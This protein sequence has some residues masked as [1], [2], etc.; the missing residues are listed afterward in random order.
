MKYN[1]IYGVSIFIPN[2]TTNTQKD[3]KF[4]CTTNPKNN[5]LY[6]VCIILTVIKNND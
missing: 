2:Y 1:Y 6:P 3:L 4:L 5:F